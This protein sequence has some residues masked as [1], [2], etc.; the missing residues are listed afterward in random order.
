MIKTFKDKKCKKCGCNSFHMKKNNKY[1]NYCVECRK[2]YVER[3]IEKKSKEYGEP[4]DASGCTKSMK[5]AKWKDYYS[6][7]KEKILIKTKK[8]FKTEKGRES[9]RKCRQKQR[10]KLMDYIVRN[11]L[12]KSTEKLLGIYVAPETITQKQIKI[13]RK[14]LLIKRELKNEMQKTT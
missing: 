2:I 7:N 4:V 1:A 9:V 8:Y 10:D 12:R 13:Y 14:V 3:Y 5:K 11:W 6:N